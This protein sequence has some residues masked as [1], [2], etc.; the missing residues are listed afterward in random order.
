MQIN[1]LVGK[2]GTG[3]SH[4]A[5]MVAHDCGA[6]VIIDD[7]L[8]IKGDQILVGYSAKKQPTRIGAIKAALFS[9]PEQSQNAQRTLARVKPKEY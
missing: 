7:G 3:K 2:S 5:I 8:L 1:A 9:D 6:D 4:R